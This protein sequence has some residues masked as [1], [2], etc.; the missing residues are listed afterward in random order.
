MEIE[1]GTQPCPAGRIGS[2]LAYFISHHELSS[3]MKAP[4]RSNSSSCSNRPSRCPDLKPWGTAFSNTLVTTDVWQVRC[5]ICRFAGLQ[6]STCNDGRIFRIETGVGMKGR[7]QRVV[8]LLRHE[9]NLMHPANDNV[10]KP[11]PK[12]Q[13]L[14][15]PRETTASAVPGRG[16]MRNPK[17]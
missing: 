10:A 17:L 1:L 11:Q 14:L 9:S 5:Q 13:V 3:L 8:D 12:R 6:E 7:R 2:V 16:L 15:H 4:S